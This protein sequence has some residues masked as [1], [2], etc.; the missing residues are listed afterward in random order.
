VLHALQTQLH[1]LSDL[2]ATRRLET[3]G[4]NTLTIRASRTPLG[5][6]LS[7]FASPLI[8]IL[9]AASIVTALLGT[10]NDSLILLATVLVN[11]ALGYWQEAKAEAAIRHLDAYIRTTARV[12]RDGQERE[13]DAEE[14]VPGDLIRITQGERV[15]ADVRLVSVNRF[16]VDEAILTGESLPVE[17]DMAPVAVDAS[18]G[19]RRSLAYLGTV[20]VEG[21]AEGVVI[22]TGDATAFG[23]IAALTVA[24]SP[25]PTPLQKAVRR[26]AASVTTYLLVLVV[27]VFLLGVIRGESLGE[28]VMV[29]V[30]LAAS[31]VPEGLPITLTVVLSVGVERLARR[32][33]V[34]RKLLAS[35]T[36]GS[37][38]V[39]LTDKTGTL[40]EARM[41]LA[42][43]LPE[44]GRQPRELLVLALSCVD[45]V[46]EN[47]SDSPKDWSLLGRPMETSLVRESVVYGADLRT[48]SP[49]VEERLPFTSARKF[50]G[51]TTRATGERLDIR[52]GAPETVLLSPG[53]P[54][55]LRTATLARVAAF[56]ENG[57][58]VIALASAPA[59][60]S[61]WKLEGLLGFRDPVRATVPDAVRR[62]QADGVRV[63]IVTGDHPGTARAVGREVGILPPDAPETAVLTG[64][65][66]EAL[67]PQERRARLE[68]VCIFA[69]VAPEQKAA[70]VAA[71]HALG[72]VVAVTGDGVNDAPA[73]EAADIGVGVGS[74]T[75]VAKAVADL[76]L[77][78][79]NFESLVAAIEEGRRIL[80]NLRTSI[81][82]L[83]SDAFTTL[84]LTGGA[85]ILGL[86]IPL[87]P[88]QIL[89]VNFFS[90]SFPA[91]AY[92]FE[93]S[94][95]TKYR[96]E[97]RIP[98][99]QMSY[100]ILMSSLA[101]SLFLFIV[102]FQLE[103]A[104]VNQEAIRTTM[105]F[106][107][108]LGTMV[109]ALAFRSLERPLWQLTPKNNPFLFVGVAIGVLLLVAAIYLPAMSQLLG[110]VPLT[111]SLVWIS[112]GCALLQGVWIEVSKWAFTR[113]RQDA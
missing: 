11:A 56:T 107:Y 78:D 9:L 74:G 39:I 27:A 71:Y 76:I 16:Q 103:L 58:R 86:P 64:S 17:K 29:S 63:V 8:L 43:V 52:L 65:A 22:A 6:L 10:P 112:I 91:I 12:Q 49:T 3:F 94:R 7:Q 5:I 77:L 67:S 41:S 1:G 20:A 106:A 47:P 72:A 109:S 85:L 88:L 79:N 35:E 31:A 19:D 48:V 15:P 55:P 34:V 66:W 44:Q 36:L 30:A 51:C 99:R 40:T 33:A 75:D 57:E 14:L 80:G 98:D 54:E 110:T 26:F 50:S 89:Y 68:Q 73:L 60:T 108:G 38:S 90:D 83:L 102:Y 100:L 84:A 82:Y 70:I 59:G 24:T 32:R 111:R 69:R 46:I 113:T 104:G 37:T 87:L 45:V 96:H 81:V 61:E 62:I 92:A 23:K 28:M 53:I 18:L 13:I 97:V 95:G 105:F 101:M 25:Q 4:A 2:E 42:Q 21:Y 93:K